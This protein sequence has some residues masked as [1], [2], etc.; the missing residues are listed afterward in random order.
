MEIKILGTGCPKCQKLEQIA[1]DVAA[2]RG[3]DAKFEHIRDRAEI[4]KYPVIGTPALVIEGQVKAS[5]RI[6]SKEEIAA[7]LDNP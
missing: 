5:G 1:R 7:W 2:A 4:L 6:P 3:I